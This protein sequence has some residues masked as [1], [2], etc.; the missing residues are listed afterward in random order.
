MTRQELLTWGKKSLTEAGKPADEARQWLLSCLALSWHQ[1][2]MVPDQSVSNE[3]I[4]VYQLGIERRCQGKP[5]QSIEGQVNFYGYSYRI[6]DNVLT[7][8][9]ETE[10]LIEKMVICLKKYNNPMVLDLGTGSGCIGVTVAME[11]PTSQVWLVDLSAKALEVAEE[12]ICRYG[13]SDRCHC[14]KSDLLTDV[15]R[16]GFDGI[17]SNPPYIPTNQ[18][19]NLEIEVTGSDPCLALDGG[20]DGLVYYRQITSQA[21]AYLKPG[22]WIGYETGWNQGEEVSRLLDQAGFEQ[23]EQYKDYNGHD[24]IVIGQLKDKVEMKR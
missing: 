7:P 17:I 8:R 13:L 21:E 6:T 22:G 19:A 16:L 12:N 20:A 5:F 10:L 9:P 15:P 11:I 2:L 24:R 23:I 3:A 4:R 18:L 1:Y 14:I